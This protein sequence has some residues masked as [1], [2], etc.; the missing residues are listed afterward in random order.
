MP[1]V[2]DHELVKRIGGGSYGDVWLARN[3]VGT[4]RAVKVVF[5]D[6]FTD[7]RPY[8]R[9]F[10]G[11]QKFEPLSR[12]NEG[13]IDILQI[14][15]NHE[16]GYFYYVMEL[17]DDAVAAPSNQLSVIS[18]QSSTSADQKQITDHRLLN[19]GVD[20]ASYV[21]KTLAKVLLQRGRL[22]VSECLELGLTLNLGLAHL[23]RA[24][25]I[26]R[27]IK[28][29]NIIFVGGVPK[30]AD[31][32]LVIEMAEARSYVGT[33]GFIPPEGPNSPQAD[34]FSLG[35]VLYEAG[36]GKDRKDFPEPFTQI[37]ETP[38][39][40]EL[41]EFNAILLK[42]CAANV[43]ERYR[44]AEEM[45]ADLALLQSGGSVRRHRKL[46]GQ[47]RFVQ[48]AGAGVTAIALVATGLYFWQSR[49]ARQMARL[50]AEARHSEQ[51]ARQNLYA[52]DIN[53]AQQAL[54]ADNL[55]QARVL[56][57]NHIPKPG[58]SDLRGFEWRHLW[59][60]SQGDELFSLPGHAGGAWRVAF[61]PDGHQL[62]TSG[63]DGAVRLWD[64]A[65]RLEIARLE[66][67]TAVLS[68]CFSPKT[69]LLATASYEGVRLWDTRTF[70]RLQQLPD[71]I[72]QAKFSPDGAYLLTLATNRLLLW[73]TADWSVVNSMERPKPRGWE[74][75]TAFAP[76]GNHFAVTVDGG[77]GFFSVPDLR[78]TGRLSKKKSVRPLISF[79]PDNQTLATDGTGFD[80]IL[81][82]I[83]RQRELKVLHGHVDHLY[84]ARFSPDGSRVATCSAD[85]TIKVWDV[86][87]GELLNTLKGQADEV[88]DLAYSPDGKLL[89]SAGMNDGA[90]ELWDAT[91]TPRP[92]AFRDSL[93]PV[94][95]DAKGALL[96]L[97]EK[98][99]L[100]SVDPATMKTRSGPGLSLTEDRNFSPLLGNVSSDC[101]TL[102]LW[103]PQ[104]Q[105]MEVWDLADRRQLCSVGS[106]ASWTRF[107]P[108]RQW[109]ITDTGNQTTT[110]WQLPAG[111]AR[112][113]FTNI[114]SLTMSPGENHIVTD[115][116]T[117]L[118]LWEI[119]G[120]RFRLLRTFNPKRGDVTAVGFSPDGSFLATAQ[121]AALIKLWAIPSGQEVG[122]FSG[123][124]RLVISLAFSPDG[125]TLASI[126]DDRTVRLWHV[127]TRRELMRFQ[128]AKEDKGDFALMFS[129]DGRALAASRIDEDGPITW[130]WLAP[131]F[132]EISA[133]GPIR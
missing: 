109:M 20:P 44:S 97:E 22:P 62:A 119:E 17:A 9:E 100:I 38:D 31:I 1:V 47:L 49:H 123:H 110:I 14:G 64:P 6:R 33:E 129:P 30:L 128:A 92:A 11:I 71:A 75:A 15:R 45:N 107:A 41:L 67:S 24:G 63:G 65:S 32:G 40:G 39:V 113:V 125:R 54:L 72:M 10:N 37:A 70:A 57:R 94:G 56:L 85:Q 16:S 8:E 116:V 84:A 23:H 131:S 18:D 118:K 108:K 43:V 2:P 87:A 90:I 34:L 95:F 79:S 93:R 81:W 133:A 4:W 82:N 124:T 91:A 103:V 66:D 98:S 36:M 76:S 78:E 122:S 48:R 60:Q 42:A 27:D 132:P 102:A 35:K 121:E 55:R 26:H 86:A 68:L 13:F 51:L 73:N 89:A 28:P 50:A 59:Q 52:A 12:S 126:C 105:R 74:F 117:H 58:E 101:R 106:A 130:V 77:I 53:L 3:V 96:T 61:S 21:P 112:F 29:S 80:V 5:R 111:A 7:A 114:S 19:T 115:E 83:P 99:R 88:F 25:L 46:A 127:A 104:E 120:N 69:A